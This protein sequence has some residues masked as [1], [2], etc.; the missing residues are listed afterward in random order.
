MTQ[1]EVSVSDELK[2]MCAKCKP[3][4]SKTMEVNVMM[5]KSGKVTLSP[6]GDSYETEKPAKGNRPK[7]V[8]SVLKAY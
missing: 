4:Q 1:P 8:D 7:V 3:G 2:S 5:D 6:H